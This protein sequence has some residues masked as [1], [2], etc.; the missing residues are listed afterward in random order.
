MPLPRTRYTT[1]GDLTI[2]YQVVGDGPID[3]VAV[4][5]GVT[6]IDA[7]W[8]HP[9]Y[10]RSNERMGTFSRYVLF[11]KRGGG[12]S[13]RLAAGAAPTLE[14][15]MDDI[16][17]VM[18]AAGS[19]SA[20][21]YGVAD[22]G[23]LS[24]LFAAT[25]PERVRGLILLSTY[26]RRLRADDHPWA[27]TREEHRGIVE[28]IVAGWG[29]PDVERGGTLFADVWAAFERQSATPAAARAVYELDADIDVR[30]AL[31]T[32]RVPTLVIH[33]A[34]GPLAIAYAN[35]LAQHIAGA[36]L[37][38][39]PGGGRDL[40][41]EDADLILAEIQEFVTGARPV[42][43]RDR[44]LATVLFTDIVDSARRATELG[45]AGWRDLLERHH[46]IVRAELARHRGVEI[47][48]AGD[49]FFATF[50]GPGRAIRCALAIRAALRPL[51]IEIRIGIH[52]GECE[53]IAGK[54]GGIAAIIGARVR[55]R[56]A[57]GEILATGTVRDLVVGSG[58]AF[59][60]RGSQELKGV[61]GEWALLAIVSSEPAPTRA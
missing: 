20:V 19:P 54:V 3:I 29:I 8:Q 15:R 53:S 9:V 49:G 13:D 21:L 56:A 52:T 38:I 23:P 50:D 16:R 41:D 10:A 1:S 60:D 42:A 57:P 44:Y 40:S 34:G 30:P 58:L 47:D 51:G 46:A 37:V 33:R 2:A 39:V 28:R 35:Y 43:E 24:I 17:A 11:D 61:P 31:P 6:N 25:Y 45:D 26:A 5:G 55:E 14:E 59:D 22:G 27:P 12:L 48:T 36:K 18:D 32:L 7:I 4:P